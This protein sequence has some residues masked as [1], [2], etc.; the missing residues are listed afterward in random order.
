[1]EQEREHS[2]GRLEESEGTGKEEGERIMNGVWGEMT[3]GGRG[4]EDNER[5]RVKERNGKWGKM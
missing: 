4:L 5:K 3:W 1:M 2:P